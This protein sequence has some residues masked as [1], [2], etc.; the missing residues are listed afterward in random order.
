MPDDINN[1]NTAEGGNTTPQTEDKTFTQAD[2]N[3]IISERLQ[4][5]KQKSDTTLA[6]REQELTQRELQLTAREQLN[7]L[8]LSPDLLEALNTSSAE[9]LEKSLKLIS[10]HISKNNTPDGPTVRVDFGKQ[11]FGSSPKGDP[12]RS[13]MGLDGH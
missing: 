12:I 6:Q 10:E 7:E 3:K 8:G 4:K 9:A 13:A 5:E 1:T 11:S 2:V